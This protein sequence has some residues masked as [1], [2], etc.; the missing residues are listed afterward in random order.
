[1]I[2]F[3]RYILKH[4]FSGLQL[5]EVRKQLLEL[6]EGK[7]LVLY[8]TFKT[9]GLLKFSEDEMNQLRITDLK[10]DRLSF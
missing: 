6:L 1:M 10:T 2:Y 4:S 7:Q 8:D 9:I 5:E 3:K